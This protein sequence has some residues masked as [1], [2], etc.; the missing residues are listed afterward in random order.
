[1]R[2]SWSWLLVTLLTIG[3]SPAWAAQP[4]QPST[5]TEEITVIGKRVVTPTTS[6][7]VEDAFSDYPLLGANFAK[8]LIIWNHPAPYINNGPAVPPVRALEGMAALGWDISRLQR[9]GRLGG[10]WEAKAGR[11]D[12]ALAVEIAAAKA[13]G[14]K[15]IILAGQEV[16]A[17]FALEAGKTIDGL[18]AIIAFAPNT[19]V[20]WGFRA[21]SPYVANDLNN[22]V[23]LAHTWDQLAHTRAERLIVLFP[24]DDEQIAVARGPTAR[25][26]LD[27]RDMPF[28]LVDETSQVRGNAAADT[29]EFDSYA[30][31]LDLFLSPELTPHPGEF[32]CGADEIPLALAQMGVKPHGGESWFG[33]STRGQTIYLELPASGHGPVTYGW[34]VGANGKTKAGVRALDA[35]FIGESFTAALTPDQTLRGAR[36]APLFRLT[37]DQEDGTR[38]AVT[39]HRL[40]GN[41]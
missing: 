14:Y 32:H 3:A 7:W 10:D 18:Y 24:T 12:D 20:K 25:E 21:S 9:N 30:S 26:I 27:K 38:D 16:G 40:S 6:Y 19:G 36:H 39:L 23:I 15:R 34:G 35:T 5:P 13:E 29:P 4:A 28:L 33:Y 2:P 1:M 8:G 11:T 31:C 17:A 41:S 37:I 22:P